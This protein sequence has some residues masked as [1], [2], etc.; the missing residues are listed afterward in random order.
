[1][2]VADTSFIIDLIRHDPGALALQE[3]LESA[4]RQPSVTPVT[5]LELYYGAYRSS[6]IE[7]NIRQILAFQDIWE[8]L[9]FT[10]EVYHAFGYLSARLADRGASLGNF[11]EVIA[12]FALVHDGEIVTRDQAFS[13]VPDPSVIHY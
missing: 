13:D 6:A 5:L 9:P 2:P 12:A 7:Q 10:D 11:D 1:M 8:E 4:D 3:E